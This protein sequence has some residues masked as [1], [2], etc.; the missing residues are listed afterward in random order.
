MEDVPQ[1]SQRKVGIGLGL[2]IL[3]IPWL[4]VWL[5]FRRG[6]S[7]KARGVGIAWT[8]FYIGAATLPRIPLNDAG[9][10]A[11][12]DLAEQCSVFAPPPVGAGS[13]MIPRSRQDCTV[14]GVIGALDRAGVLDKTEYEPTATYQK[15]L[16]DYLSNYTPG[17][18]DLTKPFAV[19]L[20][21]ERLEYDADEGVLH[22]TDAVPKLA[23]FVPNNGSDLD[24]DLSF[25]EASSTYDQ[26]GTYAAQNGF[27]AKETVYAD[28]GTI[29]GVHIATV[30]GAMFD[31]VTAEPNLP[32]TPAEAQ[33]AEGK[34]AVVLIGSLAEPV[35]INARRLQD[36]TFSTPHSVDV[37]IR[38]LNFRPA[39]EMVVRTDTGQVLLSGAFEGRNWPRLAP[40]EQPP[41]PQ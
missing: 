9:S 34:I 29:F 16:H 28:R 32:F 21:P 1:V 23:P 5:L 31:G 30:T 10:G 22:A 8:I 4:F 11:Q 18:V 12:S 24:A 14:A 6:Y 37:E 2:L 26:T 20:A 13:I 27:G 15:R 3:I 19:L 7:A 35:V 33:A 36:A 39:A 40:P 41:H 25:A 38:E 17:G